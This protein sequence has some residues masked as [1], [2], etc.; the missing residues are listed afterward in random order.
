[1]R[2]KICIFKK[3]LKKRTWNTHE[4]QTANMPEY[5]LFI[6]G[7]NFSLLEVVF[8]KKGFFKDV[9]NDA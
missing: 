2:S 4:K 5:I 1:M 8:K 6:F 9:K 7:F 3:V